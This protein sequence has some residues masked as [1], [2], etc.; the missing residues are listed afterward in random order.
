[1]E[2]YPAIDIYE[3]KAVR[4]YKGDYEQMTVYHDDP[5]TVAADFVAKGARFIHMVDLEGAKSG[6]TPNLETIC[7]VKRESGMFCQV[8]GGIRSM[9]IVRTYLEAGLDRVILGTAAV[10]D[11]AFA[12]EAVKAYGEKIAI[13]VDMK[14]GFV[15]VKGWTEKSMLEG[16]AFCKQMEEIGIKTVICTDIS[17]DGAMQGPN[18]KLYERLA[19]EL[20]MQIIASGGVS[21]I[22]DISRLAKMNIHGAIVG[23]AYYTGAVDLT[24]AI[25]VA[26]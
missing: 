7:R 6:T 12:A 19:N 8:G 24:E 18:H 10:T 3:G 22:A 16:F 11:P 4:L 5:A 15:A 2:I 14:D 21:S 17:R 23:K 1:M 9:E 25:E 26:R 13:G 20:S